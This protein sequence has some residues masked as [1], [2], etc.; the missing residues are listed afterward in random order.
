MENSINQKRYFCVC[1]KNEKPFYQESKKEKDI[2]LEYFRL[3]VETALDDENEENVY[4]A[5]IIEEEF[6]KNPITDSNEYQLVLDRKII[7][8]FKKRIRR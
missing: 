2:I 8:E 1:T 4:E 7:C 6:I 5:K 3:V